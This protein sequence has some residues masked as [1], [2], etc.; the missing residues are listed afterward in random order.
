MSSESNA[1]S[2]MDVNDNKYSKKTKNND[3]LLKNAVEN[4]L[5]LTNYW[6]LLREDG[7]Y[8]LISEM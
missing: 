1:G 8:S 7:L 2:L 3:F 5:K 6:L 4:V